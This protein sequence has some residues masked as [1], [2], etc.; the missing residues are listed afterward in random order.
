[1][2]KISKSLPKDKEI[3]VDDSV[4]KI[5]IGNPYSKI[6]IFRLWVLLFL[7]LWT[8]PFGKI[9][10]MDVI[11]NKIEFICQNYPAFDS[12]IKN[13]NN[14]TAMHMAGII[15]FANPILLLCS[16]GVFV[17]CILT[18]SDHVHYKNYIKLQYPVFSVVRFCKG[19]F[20]SLIIVP[21][22]VIFIWSCDA[23]IGVPGKSIKFVDFGM[24]S[25]V[26]I[27]YVCFWRMFYYLISGVASIFKVEIV[28]LFY[29]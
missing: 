19:F 28:R 10:G 25:I 22:F 1:M 11:Q 7:I 13:G 27:F 2:K 23:G 3:S 9:I 12:A 14:D 5:N 17:Y 8:A 29:V 20:S 26:S 18:K 21:F 24:S 15:I 6:F 16:I 4:E